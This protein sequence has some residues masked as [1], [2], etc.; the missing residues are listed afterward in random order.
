MSLRLMTTTILRVHT[1]FGCML[2][3]FD[4]DFGCCITR[5]NKTKDSRDMNEN[6]IV[7]KCAREEMCACKS[8][9]L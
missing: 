8:I 5:V 2:V 6:S 9:H 1:M 7:R 4:A 3:D